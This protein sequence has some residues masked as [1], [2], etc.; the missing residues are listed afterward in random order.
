MGGADDEEPRPVVRQPSTKWVR[1]V[2]GR[3][4]G[5]NWP[6]AGRRPVSRPRLPMK[7]A[8]VIRPSRA[9]AA[10]AGPCHTDS[11]SSWPAVTRARAR[12]SAWRRRCR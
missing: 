4:K 12:S 1:R 3:G 5:A 11:T 8:S 2:D 10:R 6:T 9:A 7:K